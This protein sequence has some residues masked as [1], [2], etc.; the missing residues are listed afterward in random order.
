MP[1][2]GV[3]RIVA[4]SQA[5][6]STAFSNASPR[7]ASSFAPT[8]ERRR[9]RAGERRHVGPD[10]DES[11]GRER[12]ALPLRVDRRHGLG[13]HAFADDA[14]RGRP[15]QHLTGRSRLL[16]ASRDVDG[17]ARREPLVRRRVQA[18]DDDLAGVDPG[19]G[20]DP[21]AV[22]PVE[23]GVQPLERV[24]ELDGR[25]YCAGSVVF[26]DDRHAEHGHHGVADELLHGSAVALQGGLRRREVARHHAAEGL[27]VEAFAES[28]RPGQVGEDDG[29][30]FPRGRVGG[31]R[32]ACAAG[33]AEPRAVGVHSPALCAPHG[34]SVRPVSR[35]IYA[36]ASASNRPV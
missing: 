35:R 6:A 34:G 26:P 13:D 7:A 24:T 23:L 20:R 3:P 17:I 11:P 16:Q 10:G 8:D 19:P 22:L 28:R 18:A 31:P 25:P 2:P 12:L 27:G 15:E 4:S 29:H 5:L 14:V 21:D 36:G 33:I 1:I 30:G 9:D 32:E